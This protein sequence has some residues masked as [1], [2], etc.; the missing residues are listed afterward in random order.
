MCPTTSATEISAGE[1]KLNLE[2]REQL[3]SSRARELLTP[4]LRPNAHYHTVK[5]GGAS[6]GD[7]A[8]LIAASA[9]K[10]IARKDSLRVVS[11]ADT[12]ASLGEDEALKVLT[13]LCGALDACKKL[14]DIDM[15]NNA[16]GE[17]GVAA[18][19]PL[20]QGQKDL[21]SISFCNNGLAP[22]AAKLIR[23]FL[24]ASTRLKKVHFHNNLLETP[25]A[26][27]IAHLV[28]AA[29]QLEDLRFSSLRSGEAGSTALAKALEKT[30][31]L[32]YLDVS[33]NTFG[34]E[35]VDALAHALSKHGKLIYLNVKDL[36]L[37]VSQIRAILDAIAKSKAPIEHLDISSNE[38]GDDFGT[39]IGKYIQKTPSLKKILLD[40][41]DL[42]D[43]GVLGMLK[44]VRTGSK[45]ALEDI[46][47]SGNT[48]HRSGAI[49]MAALARRLPN[50][51]RINLSHNCVPQDLISKI[52]DIFA[53]STTFVFD[54]N[55]PEAAD[56]ERL[57]PAMKKVVSK[58][59]ASLSTEQES[60]ISGAASQ[61]LSYFSKLRISG[62]AEEEVADIEQKESPESREED[63]ASESIVATSTRDNLSET[64]ATPSQQD[65]DEVSS[66]R[67]SALSSAQKLRE[68]TRALKQDVADVIEELSELASSP[69][70][71]TT[72]RIPPGAIV[73][74]S[75]PMINT[76]NAQQMRVVKKSLLE[77]FLD[78]IAGLLV[79][80]FI[81]I[82]IMAIVQSR[83]EYT[84]SFVPL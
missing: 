31:E 54:E 26:L 14:K 51:K 19:A 4:L 44:E 71:I 33:D 37:S 65:R 36:D 6:W 56:E 84:F 29:P 79:S 43:V 21:E 48:I 18:C 60:I 49:G 68:Q 59:E 82:L 62:N 16:L 52:D 38:N 47:V 72:R 69:G 83:E 39:I 80:S 58:L 11:L 15:S 10:N 24:V 78:V 40:D 20:L 45:L 23:T 55:D 27:Q 46:S 35:A 57:D 81:L 5:L 63:E 17:R 9:L 1:F 34:D 42:D 30:A 74:D 50:A 13:S 70:E 76:N 22:G 64:P 2:S 32:K 3:G 67:P 28:T 66:A 61:L 73:D 41:Y 8:A 53:E 25:G 77:S 75:G 12:I 7:R